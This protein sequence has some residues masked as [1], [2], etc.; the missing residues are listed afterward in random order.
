[1]RL[2]LWLRLGAVASVAALVLLATARPSRLEA[3]PA[4]EA[5]RTHFLILDSGVA[6]DE[7][8]DRHYKE[9]GAAFMART[10]APLGDFYTKD[11]LY[12]EAENP[13]G[14]PITRGRE[15]IADG[16]QRYFKFLDDNGRR[17]V[18]STARVIAR[19]RVG[20]FAYDVGYWRMTTTVPAKDPVVTVWKYSTVF[21]RAADGRWQVHIE[22]TIPVKAEMFDG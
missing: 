22:T 19:E 18:E 13:A 3:A 7:D 20:D 15:A 1:V 6:A 4:D 21:R 2:G 11:A 8:L 12:L 9:S 17:V 5:A 10:A 14:S 16:F